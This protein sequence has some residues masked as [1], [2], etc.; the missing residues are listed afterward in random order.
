M[1]GGGRGRRIRTSTSFKSLRTCPK[2]LLLCCPYNS[3][4]CG[5]RWYSCHHRRISSMGCPGDRGG[6]SGCIVRWRRHPYSSDNDE[7]RRLCIPTTMPRIVFG[8]Q[9]IFL[10]GKENGVGIDQQITTIYKY[11]RKQTH[12]QIRF[13]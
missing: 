11:V 9:S 2:W 10:S 7:L 3:R 8:V 5:L 13:C 4:L 12:R 6:C 1:S